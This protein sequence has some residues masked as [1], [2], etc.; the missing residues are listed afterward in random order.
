MIFSELI[1]IHYRIDKMMLKASFCW[2]FHVKWS[3]LWRSESHQIL[4][5]NTRKSRFRASEISSFPCWRMCAVLWG[6][7]FHLNSYGAKHSL[8]AKL[9]WRTSGHISSYPELTYKNRFA[10]NIFE[11]K[12]SQKQGLLTGSFNESSKLNKII[13]LVKFS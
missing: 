11:M 5:Q 9:S 2:Y 12:I 6:A 10:E 8:Y 1:K 13:N 4:S 7:V 3:I